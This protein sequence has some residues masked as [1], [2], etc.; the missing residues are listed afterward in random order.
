[1]ENTICISDKQDKK[2]DC[3]ITF[4]KF[5]K[6]LDEADYPSSQYK[7]QE[8]DDDYSFVYSKVEGDNLPLTT[9][10]LESKPCLDPNDVSSLGK[11][12]FYPLERDRNQHACS[13]IKQYGKATDSRYKDLGLSISE[14]EV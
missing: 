4:M 5:I 3:P 12:Q 11:T 9:F 8:V 7:V 6:K 1:M 10:H 14:Y 13:V 2:K